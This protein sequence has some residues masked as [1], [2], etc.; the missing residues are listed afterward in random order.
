MVFR[1][2][3]IFFAPYPVRWEILDYNGPNPKPRLRSWAQN[4]YQLLGGLYGHQ[5]W[6]SQLCRILKTKLPWMTLLY[7]FLVT[8]E[9]WYHRAYITAKEIQVRQ[10]P[11]TFIFSLFGIMKVVQKVSAE[12]KEKVI[13]RRID[14]RLHPVENWSYSSTKL[15]AR[16][17]DLLWRGWPR[18]NKP[19]SRSFYKIQTILELDRFA[20]K[21]LPRHKN[22]SRFD[23]MHAIWGAKKKN[24]TH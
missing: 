11:D 24:S 15:V 1:F 16:R 4:T 13:Q 9:L 22:N 21:K 17:Q 3:S 12:A 18:L 2:H 20:T 6:C 5:S 10:E 23:F 7:C 14:P 19:H 8:L